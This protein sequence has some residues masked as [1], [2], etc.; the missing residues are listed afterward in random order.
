MRMLA[1]RVLYV[2]KSKE[3]FGDLIFYF[4]IGT[5]GAAVGEGQFQTA[6]VENICLFGVSKISTEN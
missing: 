1:Y 4:P 5:E 3:R 6:A 2:V